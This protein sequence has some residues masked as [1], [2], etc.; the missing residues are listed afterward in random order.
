MSIC[1]FTE[2]V[3]ERGFDYI[4]DAPM[5]EYTTFKIGGKA[6]ILIQPRSVEELLEIIAKSGCYV[7]SFGL[8]SISKESLLSM[9][10]AWADPSKYAEQ[11]RIIRK[12]GIDISTEMV[13]SHLP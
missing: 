10:K 6:D 3:A 4:F 12:H 13:V 11:I 9:N 8:E 1:E 7:L 5:S 2:F